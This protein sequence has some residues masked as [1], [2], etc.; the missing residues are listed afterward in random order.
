MKNEELEKTIKELT[1]ILEKLPSDGKLLSKEQK[2]QRN[3]LF[4]K[5]EALYGLKDARERGSRSDEIH[6]ATCYSVL[7]SWGEKHPRL[8]R[9]IISNLRWRQI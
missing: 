7:D 2:K 9:F 4:K 6:Y 3:L 5:L 1:D 8:V